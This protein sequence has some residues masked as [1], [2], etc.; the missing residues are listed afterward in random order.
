MSGKSRYRNLAHYVTNFGDMPLSKLIA[1]HQKGFLVER[2]ETPDDDSVKFQYV[3]AVMDSS[4]EPKRQPG[5]VSRQNLLNTTV[6]EIKKKKVSDNSS[7]VTIG[8]SADNDI[9]LYNRLVSK[10]HAYLDVCSLCQTCHIFDADSANGTFLNHKKIIPYEKYTL[11]DGDEIAFG[12]EIT[13][14]Y[15]SPRAFHSFLSGFR[16][17]VNNSTS[18]NTF[19]AVTEKFLF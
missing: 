10:S 8:R 1:D 17:N 13:V 9:I 12:P 3:T 2:Y 6:I 11:T 15:L 7:S 14:M 16:S 5:E 18:I 4:Y 19:S